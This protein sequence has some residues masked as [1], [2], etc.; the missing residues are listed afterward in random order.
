MQKT[1][2]EFVQTQK[3]FSVE[4]IKPKVVFLHTLFFTDSFSVNTLSYFR[5]RIE[6]EKSCRKTC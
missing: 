4:L 2:S 3:W 1:I 5:L 6:N